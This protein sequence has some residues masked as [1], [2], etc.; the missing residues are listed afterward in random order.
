M[1]PIPSQYGTF[2]EG[3]QLLEDN[4]TPDYRVVQP[5]YKPEAVAA[6]KLPEWFLNNEFTDFADSDK[7][8]M[9]RRA[10]DLLNDSNTIK[11]QQQEEDQ[12]NANA[13][14]DALIAEFGNRDPNEPFDPT[15]ALR[16][17]QELSAEQGDLPTMLA[18]EKAAKERR[19][20]IPISKNF[21]DMLAQ[22]GINVDEDT[23]REDL[24]TFGALQRAQA[25]EK[26][27]GDS[28][29][30][31]EDKKNSLLPEGWEGNPTLDD[32]KKFKTSLIAIEKS[33]FYLDELRDSISK[34]GP[35]AVSGPEYL[36][37]KSLITK[38]Q[39]ALKEKENL[40]AALTVNEEFLLNGAIPQILARNDI[41]IGQ[42]LVNSGF[43]RDPVDAID[44]LQQ[45]LNKELEIE[46]G[47]R[48]IHRPISPMMQNGAPGDMIPR[49]GGI[50]GSGVA[51][52]PGA[53]AQLPPGFKARSVRRIR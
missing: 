8:A 22:N 38:L 42:L 29:S 3:Y 51:L 7:D 48:N 2:P 19:N 33:N 52:P 47:A 28:Q 4:L 23:T 25:Y 24:T 39:L 36:R 11:L 30:R 41:G 49:A 44:Q 50:T 31:F 20:Y 9:S 5:K 37:Q 1:A 40:G 18:I 10:Q 27:V 35:D 13:R 32:S 6:V 45:T 12:A 17:V 46:A 15:T 34:A 16:R 53:A 14:R 26:S 21:R 43:G